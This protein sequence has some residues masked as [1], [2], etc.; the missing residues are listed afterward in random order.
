[1]V[2]ILFPIIT[3]IGNKFQ[4]QYWYLIYYKKIW[5][6]FEIIS[7][8]K[9]KIAWHYSKHTAITNEVLIFRCLPLM[10][11]DAHFISKRIITYCRIVNGIPFLTVTE[12][13]V[14]WTSLINVLCRLRLTMKTTYIC[15]QLNPTEVL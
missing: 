1:M 8:K 6:I 9:Y 2:L 4:D 10:I 14:N 3:I 13:Y 5:N 15:F 12:H 11:L 7:E